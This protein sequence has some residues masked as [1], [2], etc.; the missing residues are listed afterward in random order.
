LYHFNFSALPPK[1]PDSC[2]QVAATVGGC[3]AATTKIYWEEDDGS[4]IATG[5]GI[6]VSSVAS[7]LKTAHYIQDSSERSS[8]LSMGNYSRTWSKPYKS[9]YLRSESY[10]RR[11]LVRIHIKIQ[12]SRVASS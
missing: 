1:S 7:T 6:A 5:A 2:V 3:A 4:D 12:L 11:E 8:G 9:K 10:D